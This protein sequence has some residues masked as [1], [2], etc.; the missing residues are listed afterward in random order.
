M[1]ISDWSSDVC[2]SDLPLPLLDHV[3]IGLSDESA[4][5][6]EHLAPPI[7]QLR[8]SRIDQPRGR[9]SA[10]FC[11][12]AAVL[13]GYPSHAL[14]GQL[15]ALLHR[16]GEMGFVKRL[17]LVDVEVTTFLL[18]GLAVRVRA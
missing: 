14:A 11:L 13:H 2:S 10:F 15:A 12:R 18:I 16:G 5:P 4:D 1:R 17:V 6:G 7:I 9:V 8:D 3:G